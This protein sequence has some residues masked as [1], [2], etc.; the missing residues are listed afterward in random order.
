MAAWHGIIDREV[1]AR[2]SIMSTWRI[3]DSIRPYPSLATG[4]QDVVCPN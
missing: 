1:L 4:E 3:T 2:T